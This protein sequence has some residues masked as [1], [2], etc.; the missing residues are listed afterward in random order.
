MVD[1]AT[2]CAQGFGYASVPDRWDGAGND[3]RG[4]PSQTYALTDRE[5]KQRRHYCTAMCQTI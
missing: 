1:V 4:T 3:H 2:T 5:R